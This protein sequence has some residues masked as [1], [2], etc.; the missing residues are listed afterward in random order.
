MELTRPNPSKRA[1]RNPNLAPSQCGANLEST[2][3]RLAINTGKC[4]DVGSRRDEAVHLLPGDVA[5]PGASELV[6]K[7]V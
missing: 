4:R 3:E 5:D 2:A 1:I 6:G 7:A